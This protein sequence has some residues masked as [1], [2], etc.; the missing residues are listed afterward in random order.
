M[1]HNHLLSVVTDAR[2]TVPELDVRYETQPDV[3][4]GKK[5]AI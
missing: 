3:A 1:K 5:V 2:V 4:P